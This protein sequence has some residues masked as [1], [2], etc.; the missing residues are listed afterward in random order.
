MWEE[1][2]GYAMHNHNRKTSYLSRAEGTHAARHANPIHTQKHV[3]HSHHPSYLSLATQYSHPS[4]A[5]T[6]IALTLN[7]KP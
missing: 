7:P 2:G 6:D 3:P 4:H 1:G 5:L